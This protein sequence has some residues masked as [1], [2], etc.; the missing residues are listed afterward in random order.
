VHPDFGVFVDMGIAKD[1]LLSKDYLPYDQS[2]WPIEEDEVL[3]TLKVKNKL[4]AKLSS[5][6]ELKTTNR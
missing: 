1:L 4:V 3:V 5:K 2:L 6:E